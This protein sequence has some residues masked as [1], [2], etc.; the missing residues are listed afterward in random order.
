MYTVIYSPKAQED[1]RKLKINKKAPVEVLFF[2][3]I[4]EKVLTVLIAPAVLF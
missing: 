3:Y 2:C 1:L 4:V